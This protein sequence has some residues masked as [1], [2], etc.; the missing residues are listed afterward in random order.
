MTGLT[1]AGQLR[2]GGLSETTI[3]AYFEVPLSISFQTADANP[4]SLSGFARVTSATGNQ[5]ALAASVVSR[6]TAV[7]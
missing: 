3:V 1:L 2:F 5:T 7:A 4:T 6:V